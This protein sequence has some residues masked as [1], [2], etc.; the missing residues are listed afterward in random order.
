MIHILV[1][2]RFRRVSAFVIVKTALFCQS[3]TMSFKKIP[4]YIGEK[5]RFIT[6]VQQQRRFNTSVVRVTNA[7][8]CVSSRND[9]YLSGKDLVAL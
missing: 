3:C 5:Q 7:F 4:R 9:L 2:G 1:K 8:Q 6:Q